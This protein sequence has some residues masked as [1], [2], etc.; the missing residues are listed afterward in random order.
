MT[1]EDWEKRFKE[2]EIPSGSG[3]EEGDTFLYFDEIADYRRIE[4]EY[5]GDKTLRF[6]VEFKDPE[7]PSLYLPK[8]VGGKLQDALVERE[9]D[10]DIVGIRTTRQGKG[11]TTRYTSV[12]VRKKEI[13]SV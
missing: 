2:E 10:A 1:L 9:K 4:E 6:L 7:R 13:K 5:E 8:S 11:K 3:L 12:I